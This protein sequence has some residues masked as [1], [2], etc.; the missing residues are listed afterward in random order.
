MFGTKL[1]RLGQPELAQLDALLHHAAREDPAGNLLGI[2]A[3]HLEM[4]QVKTA[5]AVL[6]MVYH[7]R[8]RKPAPLPG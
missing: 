3:L 7:M 5:I 8:F 4:G 1:P 6:R 2:A